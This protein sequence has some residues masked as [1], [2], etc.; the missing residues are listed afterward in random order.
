MRGLRSQS[1]RNGSISPLL[2][3][4]LCSFLSFTN[5]LNVNKFSLNI[6]TLNMFTVDLFTLSFLPFNLSLM[7][8]SFSFH[9]YLF[10][11]LAIILSSIYNFH[12]PFVVDFVMK[13]SSTV[14]GKA[15]KHS[16]LDGF[17]FDQITATP[18]ASFKYVI[19]KYTSLISSALNSERNLILISTLKIIKERVSV[20]GFVYVETF[21][22][23]ILT[24]DGY[25]VT[26]VIVVK[27]KHIRNVI[28]NVRFTNHL[29]M[30]CDQTFAPVVLTDIPSKFSASRNRLHIVEFD[31]KGDIYT[32]GEKINE[33]AVYS[34]NVEFKRIFTID[35]PKSDPIIVSLHIRDDWLVVQ[36]YNL[37]LN[38]VYS[39][40]KFTL[41]TLELVEDFE[42]ERFGK[43]RSNYLC[44]DLFGNIIVSNLNGIHI[45]KKSGVLSRIKLEGGEPA[46]RILLTNDSQII[47]VSLDGTIQVHQLTIII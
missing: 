12:F 26:T 10:R 38:S 41:S 24:L 4:D 16:K 8:F 40:R 5:L 39:V 27:T 22:F 25:L 18:I 1:L 3:C 42:F 17:D 11:N 43:A 46:A 15:S 23:D 45:C 21:T 19:P 35:L 6:F 7:I 29:I 2:L 33:I 36:S 14:L 9:F 37:G 20:W 30:L 13:R 44:I 32:N 47:L 34:Q 31:E 28:L